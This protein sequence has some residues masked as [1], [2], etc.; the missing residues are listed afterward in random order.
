MPP[1]HVISKETI[2]PSLPSPQNSI[3]L[4]LLDQIA[5]EIYTHLLLFYSTTSSD[6]QKLPQKLKISLSKVLNQ[7]YPLAGRIEV[8]VNGTLHIN[9]NNKGAVFIEAYSDTDL[10]VFLLSRPIN[11]FKELL[12]VKNSMFKHR[13]PLLLL[14]FTKFLNGYVLGVS[15]SHVIADGASMALFL[16]RWAETARGEEEERLTMPC[17]TSAS[18]LFPPKPHKIVYQEPKEPLENSKV[19]IKRVCLS[20]SSIRRLRESA[21]KRS[22]KPS[23]VEAVSALV[24]RSVMR[25]T[26]RERMEKV[27]VSQV[28]NLRSRLKGLSYFSIGNLWTGGVRDLEREGRQEEV[29]KVL[30]EVV[31]EVNEETVR[32]EAERSFTLKNEVKGEDDDKGRRNERLWIFSSWCRIPLY[33]SDF[34]LGEPEWI[35]CG[36]WNMKDVCILIDAKDGEGME[37]W[38]WMERD[39]MDRLENDEEFLSFVSF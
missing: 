20:S 9:C 24:L 8:P 26:G 37:A 36:I 2:K 19:V 7:F 18:T 16:N 23:R 1:I 14:Q 6:L 15:I 10:N 22:E 31:R 33:K 11:E 27:L 30:R 38:L 4:S 28:V 3:K 21:Y 35:G 25:V 17:F 5:P 12:P 29:E 39:E 32:K 34:G 13:E